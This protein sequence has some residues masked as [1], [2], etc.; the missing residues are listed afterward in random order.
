MPKHSTTLSVALVIRS[1]PSD[2]MHPQHEDRL[3]FCSHMLLQLYRYSAPQPPCE[4]L[5]SVLPTNMKSA[6]EVA[7]H[8]CKCLPS[9]V[10]L[11]QEKVFHSAQAIKSAKVQHTAAPTPALAEQARRAAGD[12]SAPSLSC[13]G[14]TGRCCKL[15]CLHEQYRVAACTGKHGQHL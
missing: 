2:H 9:P 12:A 5:R 15:H 3:G 10:C 4:L 6:D 13:A 7:P 14:N 1:C 11:S 8:V